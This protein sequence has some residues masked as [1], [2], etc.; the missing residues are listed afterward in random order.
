MRFEEIFC[1][2]GNGVCMCGDEFGE[3]F[4]EVD[5]VFEMGD[6]DVFLSL[7]LVGE[8]NGEGV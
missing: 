3:G 7:L 2:N 1:E 5:F 4:C 6:R 8:E